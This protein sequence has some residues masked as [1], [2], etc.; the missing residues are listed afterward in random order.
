MGLVSWIDRTYYPNF[1]NNWDDKLFR[2]AIQVY[3]R[4]GGA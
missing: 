4:S 3:S 1:E 2:K